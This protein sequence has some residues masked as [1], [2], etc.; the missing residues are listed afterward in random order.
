LLPHADLDP[1]CRVF[2]STNAGSTGLNLQHASTLVN[3][4]LPWNPAILEQRIARIHRMG[5]RR[6]VQIVNFIAN[7][8]QEQTTHHW[9]ERDPQTGARNL[10][11]PLPPPETA[12]QIADALSLMTQALHGRGG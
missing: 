10:K 1:H 2:L 7:G 9:I 8:T 12:R 3:L 5:Q 4:D 11:L 6:P